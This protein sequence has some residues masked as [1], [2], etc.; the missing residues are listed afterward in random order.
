M[1]ALFIAFALTDTALI[2]LLCSSQARR[3]VRRLIR[4]RLNSDCRWHPPV[5]AVKPLDRD[6]KEYLGLYFQGADVALIRQ[7]ASFF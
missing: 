3:V 5:R 1:L 4:P 2:V 7:H 6:V